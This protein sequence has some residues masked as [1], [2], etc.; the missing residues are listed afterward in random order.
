[1][2]VG[3]GFKNTHT[4]EIVLYSFVPVLLR[5][6]ATKPFTRNCVMQFCTPVCTSFVENQS[7]QAIPHKFKNCVMYVQFCTTVVLQRIKATS[8]RPFITNSKLCYVVFYQFYL[9]RIKATRVGGSVCNFLNDTI[10]QPLFLWRRLFGMRMA[11]KILTTAASHNIFSR[12]VKGYD[13]CT[14]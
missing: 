3:Q 4:P 7:H 1:M 6:K 9:L 5:I 8:S 12:S 13:L 10:F 11:C 14:I 2:R